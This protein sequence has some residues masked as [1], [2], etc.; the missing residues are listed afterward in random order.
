MQII[1][2]LGASLSVC[3]W[4][5]SE[6]FHWLPISGV[7]W[8]RSLELTCVFRNRCERSRTLIWRAGIDG[9]VPG[10]VVTRISIFFVRA[11]HVGVVQLADVSSCRVSVR[12]VPRYVLTI[13]VLTGQFSFCVCWKG[14]VGESILLRASS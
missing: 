4:W 2:R 11:N 1:D 10:P 5:K 12:E 3:D 7:V 13:I 14:R 6:H 8:A 9:F